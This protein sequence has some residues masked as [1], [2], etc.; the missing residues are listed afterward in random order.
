M[1][2]EEA[3][4]MFKLGR[5]L[6]EICRLILIF[7]RISTYIGY[8]PVT[9]FSKTSGNIQT[10][11]ANE[12][13]DTLYRGYC[14][15]F[16]CFLFL[17]SFPSVKTVKMLCLYIQLYSIRWDLT[18]PILWRCIKASLQ[19]IFQNLETSYD[20]QGQILPSTPR[21]DLKYIRV[22]WRVL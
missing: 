15:R 10:F 6:K 11:A 8:G 20:E 16:Y 2:I 4:N 14:C 22:A 7:D 12:K 1:E 17:W 21:L 13:E 18:S 19:S 3:V 9:Y 5:K